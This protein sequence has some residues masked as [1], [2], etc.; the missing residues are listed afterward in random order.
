MIKFPGLTV[1]TQIHES[2]NSLVYR[3]IRQFDQQPIILKLLKEDY[4]TPSQL[5]HYRQEYEILRKLDLE[6]VVKVYNLQNYQN[7]LVI[8]LEDFGGESLK[9][10]LGEKSFSLSE[11]LPIAL[12]ITQSLGQVHHHNIIH[13][14][15]NPSN[16]VFNPQTGQVKLIDFGISTVLARENP[17][18]TSPQLLEGTLAYISPEQTGR[19]NRSLDYRTDFYSLG[20][21]FYELLTHQ[22]PF[23]TEEA[24]ELVHCHIAKQPVP[25]HVLEPDIPK[26]IS[27]I[28]MK[29]M[30]KTA[31]ERYQSAWG[32]HRD[33]AECWHQLQQRGKIS[34]FILASADIS[35]RFQIPQKLYGREREVEILL[36]AFERVATGRV[37]TE[38]ENSEQVISQ[39][40][41]GKSHIEMMLVEGYSGI[42]KSVL[43]QELYQ[44]ITQ[45]RGY[46]IRGKFEQLQRNVPYSAVIQA[47]TELVRQLLAESEVQLQQ[48]REKLLQS[49]GSNGQVIIDVIPEVELIVGFQSPVPTLGATESQNRFNLVFQNFIAVFVSPLHPL[50]IFLDD[51]QWADRPSLKLMELLMTS[52]EPGLFLIGAYRDNEVSSAHPL[53]LTLKDIKNT[54]T[55]VNKIFLKPLDLITVN[56]LIS[57]TLNCSGKRTLPLAELVLAKTEGNPFFVNEFLKSLYAENL[58][59]FI[60]PQPTL[61]RGEWRWDLEQ[62]KARGITENVVEL[63]AAKIQ[64]LPES[65]QQVLKL[66]A[67]IGSRFELKTLAVVSEKSPQETAVN[68]H[69]AVVEGLILPLSDAYEVIG[70]WESS[71]TNDQLP[72][73]DYQSP[74]PVEYKFIHDR[75]QQAV[76]S[77]IS[78][79]VEVRHCRARTHRQVGQLLLQNIPANQREEKIFDIVNQLNLGIELISDQSERDELAKLNLMAGKKA[80]ASIAYEPAFKYLIFG[81]E[82]FN[83]PQSPLDQSSWQR[84]YNLTLELYVEAA[85]AAYLSTN[86]EQMEKLAEV[87][88]MQAI[89]LLDKI[90]I[91]EIL[92]QSLISQNRLLEAIDTGIKILRLLGLQFPEKPKILNIIFSL[93]R[94]KLTLFRKNIKDL[95][96]LPDMTDPIALAAMRLMWSISYAAYLAVPELIPLLAFKMVNLSIKYGNASESASGYAGYGTILC[97]II[98][99]ID[100]GYQLGQLALSLLDKFNAKKLKAKTFLVVNDL[101]RHWKEHLGETLPALIDSFESGIE[102]GDLEFAALSINAYVYHAYFIGKELGELEQEMAIYSEVIGKLKQETTLYLLKIWRQTVLT[103]LGRTEHQCRLIGEVY[104]EEK[105]LS[106][107]QEANDRTAI[108]ILYFNKLVLCYLFTEYQEAVKNAAITERYLDG[109][110]GVV[111][112]PLFHFYDSLALLAIYPSSKTSVQKRILRKVRANQKKMKKWA[113]YAPAN[114]LHKFYLVEA[115]RCRVIGQETKAIEWYDYSIA[116]AEEN[117]YIQEKALA[118][119][120]AAQYYISKGKD[121]ISKAYM[122]EARYCYLK[123][124]ATRKVRH[125]E[126]TYPQLLAATKSGIKNGKFISK[127]TNQSSGEALDLATI[128]KATQAISGEIVLDK[129]LESLMKILIENAGAQKGFLILES[130]GKLRIEASGQVDSEKV[131]VL[132]SI[133]IESVEEY[134]QTPLLSSTLINYVVRTQESVVLNDATREGQ[135]IND[136]YIKTHQAKSVLCT[137]L[138]N[139]G[140]LSGIVYLENNLTTGAFTPKRIEMLS[141]LSAQAA[142]SI[143]NAR[144]YSNMAALN[145]AYERFVPRQFLQFLDKKSIIDVQLGDQIQQEM[146]VL[147]SDIRDFTTLSESMTPQDNFKFINS[148]LSRMEPAIRENQG[149]IDKYIGDAIMALFSGAADNALK[150]GIAMLHRLTEYNQNRMKSGYEPIQIGIGIHTGSLMLGTVGGYNRMDGTVISDAVNLASRVESLTK[151]YGIPL[152]ITHQ[153][154]LRLSNPSDY[155][156]RKIDEV[157]VKGKSELVTVYEVFDADLSEIQE[158]KLATLELFKEALFHNHSQNWK[159]AEKLLLEC[160]RLNPNDKVAQFYQQCCRERNSM[161]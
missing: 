36:R 85:E 60:P 88:L 127:S 156:I 30:A 11:F 37:D 123:W 35:S 53:R 26:I 121:V 116:G 113:H 119:E 120:L 8:L 142:I 130:K 38:E 103:L 10:W 100:S 57:D 153:T 147:F 3:G 135:F 125:L 39:N 96:D 155:K 33:L 68:L 63:M 140:K 91:Y 50:V 17:S 77:L 145:T 150:A 27:D 92:I 52:S 71:M 34:T 129:L 117:G 89:T 87:V 25:P 41:K 99:A 75:I 84:Q 154:F 157:K 139:Q 15:I 111:T 46:F 48:W 141:I 58:L 79:D 31:E 97:G 109:G 93:I 29:L 13:K 134:N 72:I 138:M 146:S 70:D 56:Q 128:M 137:P 161:I 110:L 83:P 86:F 16:L 51:L 149:F 40:P 126:E 136:S 78:E 23:Q 19:M 160:L 108:F 42:G 133:P 104:D 69:S 43:V 55:I 122:Q 66:A 98:G 44:P 124:G 49:L 64:K 62:I 144:L 90:K 115:E 112:V 47:L 94:I 4:P 80:K 131:T 59:N 20:V 45:R 114:F 148:Y 101:I 143:E 1:I 18:L 159:E 107:H 74:I 65:T 76:Y 12:Q 6:G 73:T 61:E 5:I 152:L 132:Q 21:T 158:A 32:I 7:T 95:I 22:L 151:I 105:M 14:D 67:C 81:I 28:V 106:L 54:G 82:L 2:A 24:L 9:R 102:T 118:Y